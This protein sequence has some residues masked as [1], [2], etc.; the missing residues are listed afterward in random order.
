MQ[1]EKDDVRTVVYSL[2][3]A[4]GAHMLHALCRCGP[5]VWRQAH[6]LRHVEHD[7]LSSFAQENFVPFQST[8][9]CRRSE[10]SH[11]VQ[12]AVSWWS[13]LG[14]A[15]LCTTLKATR[16]T[17]SKGTRYVLCRAALLLHRTCSH[18][19]S[20]APGCHHMQ[21]VRAG[22]SVLCGIRQ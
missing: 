13:Q 7:Q 6:L 20:Q 11:F 10:R 18:V 12:M 1:P 16:S 8:C 15:S 21:R 17:L 2:S 14:R 19:W 4:P 3:F 22:R 5:A 9:S